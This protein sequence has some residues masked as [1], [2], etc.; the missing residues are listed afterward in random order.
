MLN[1]LL[2]TTPPGLCL[3]GREGRKRER[4][5]ER[6][7]ENVVGRTWL[8]LY[9]HVQSLTFMVDKFIFASL[10]PFAKIEPMKPFLDL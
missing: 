2:K 6:D 7:R 5:G 9:N 1:Q 4:E 8:C 10:L 3:T